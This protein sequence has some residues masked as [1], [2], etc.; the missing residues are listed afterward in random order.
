MAE[1]MRTTM[2]MSHAQFEPQPIR[3]GNY[4]AQS[5]VDFRLVRG[6]GLKII[7]PMERT[8]TLLNEESDFRIAMERRSSKRARASLDEIGKKYGL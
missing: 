4:T 1:T 2:T 5:L 3:K 8:T 7:S 6:Q